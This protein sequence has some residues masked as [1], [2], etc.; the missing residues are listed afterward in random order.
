MTML[1]LALAE[2]V[3]SGLPERECLDVLLRQAPRGE[4]R[5][6][7]S[8]PLLYASCDRCQEAVLVQY[9]GDTL[10]AL[11]GI[12]ELAQVLVPGAVAEGLMRAHGVGDA[13]AR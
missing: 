4:L 13:A 5:T 10:L 6:R 9:I 12:G 3:G 7:G 8:T 1:L 11:P 2:P